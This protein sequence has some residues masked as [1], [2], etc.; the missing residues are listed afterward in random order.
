MWLGHISLTAFLATNDDPRATSAQNPRTDPLASRD[1]ALQHWPAAAPRARGRLLLIHGLSSIA[2]SWWRMGPALAGDGWDVTAVD[3]AGHGGRPFSGELSETA[4]AEAIRAVVPATP[5]VLVGHSLGAVTALALLARDP[6]WARVAILE[7][8]ASLLDPQTCLALANGIVA[9]VEAVRADRGPVVARVRREHPAWA[10]E[11]VHWA[12]EGIA[13][14][15]PAPFAQRLRRLARDARPRAPLPARVLGAA[16]EAYVLAGRGGRSFTDGGSALRDADR[17]ELA[18]RLPGGHVVEIEGGHCL[19]RDAPD[20]WL[21][22]VR[23]I[24]G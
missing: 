10:D 14:M 12:V 13:Q 8:P 21:R 7:E 1:V 4:L 6:A 20:A 5:D 18:R 2:D 22:A 15:Q 3:Q 11:D 23:S 9:D 17:D 16:P 24:A 19:H